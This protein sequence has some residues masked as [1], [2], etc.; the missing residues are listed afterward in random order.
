MAARI[1][2][3]CVCR[4]HNGRRWSTCS[5]ENRTGSHSEIGLL[6]L[7]LLLLLLSRF[8]P[9]STAKVKGIFFFSDI[10]KV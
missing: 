2:A 6:L 8:S 7:L 3:P 10:I 9:H 1:P 5:L 4:L